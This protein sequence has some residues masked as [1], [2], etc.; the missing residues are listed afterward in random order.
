MA[1]ME[2]VMPM[3]TA[4]VRARRNKKRLLSKAEIGPLGG[5]FA[6]DT[7]WRMRNGQGVMD[8]EC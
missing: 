4:A 1:W 7:L 8:M 2:P 6:N 3:E 5:F